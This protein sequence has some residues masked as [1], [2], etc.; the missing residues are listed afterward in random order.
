MKRNEK[1]DKEKSTPDKEY[2]I[3][4]RKVTELEVADD[5][6]FYVLHFEEDPDFVDAEWFFGQEELTDEVK[7]AKPGDEFYYTQIPEIGASKLF[8][9]KEYVLEE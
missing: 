4:A 3:K 7:N 9:T 8:S 2:I 5:Q 6:S 1:N